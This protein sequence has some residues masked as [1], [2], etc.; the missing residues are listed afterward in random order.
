MDAI[1]NEYKNFLFAVDFTYKMSIVSTR[2][3][4]NIKRNLHTDTQR[5]ERETTK[6]KTASDLSYNEKICE[7]TEKR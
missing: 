6:K 4:A 7:M 1:K 3:R 5:Y 2:R